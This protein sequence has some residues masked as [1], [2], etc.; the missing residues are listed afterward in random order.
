[1]GGGGGGGNPRRKYLKCQFPTCGAFQW[2]SKAIGQ[3]SNLPS[4]SNPSFKDGC[5]GYEKIRHWWRECPWR[6]VVCPKGGY[7]FMKLCKSTTQRTKGKKFLVCE[8]VECKHFIWLKDYMYEE[9]KKNA[10]FETMTNLN[11][12]VSVTMGLDEFCKE[13]KGKSSMG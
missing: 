8:N 12:K 10:E 1:M 2:L 7:G 5:F 13:Y 4:M 9:G 6:T 11:V 3:S